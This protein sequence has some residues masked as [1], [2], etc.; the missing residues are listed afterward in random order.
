MVRIVRR[1][2]HRRIAKTCLREEVQTILIEGLPIHSS[3]LPLSKI[4]SPQV[5]NYRN[6]VTRDSTVRM[7]NREAVFHQRPRLNEVKTRKRLREQAWLHDNRAARAENLA[8]ALQE[9]IV[10]NRGPVNKD[11]SGQ[12]LWHTQGSMNVLD[13][14]GIEPVWTKPRDPQ[15]AGKLAQLDV[16]EQ[17][18]TETTLWGGARPYRCNHNESLD[19]HGDGQCTVVS[20]W[21]G[22]TTAAED[23]ELLW[24]RHR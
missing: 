9:S 11:S 16:V 3:W 8:S 10:E 20:G 4:C 2:S 6:I 19:S 23:C 5:E 13:E 22:R 17:P 18:V 24:M 21:P 7:T 1:N 12:S 14:G 15:M